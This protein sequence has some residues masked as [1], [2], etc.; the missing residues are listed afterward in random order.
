MAR[1]I[2][3]LSGQGRGHT[4]RAMAISDG[5]RIRRHEVVFCG[6]G[7]ARD[8]LEARGETVLPVPQLVQVVRDNQ[9]LTASTVIANWPSIRDL[10]NIVQ[11]LAG[12]FRAWQPD[13]IITDFEAFSWRAAHVLDV[14]VISLNHQQ[15]VTE[16]RYSL[17]SRHLYHASVARIIINIV[18]PKAPR[19][20]LLTSF[21]FPPVRHPKSTVIVP[22]IIR[23]NVMHLSPSPGD[24]FLVYYNQPEGSRRLLDLLHT[25][26]HRY[27]VYN[28]PAP[29]DPGRYPNLTFKPASVDSFLHDLAHCRGVLCTAGFTLMS[30]ALYLGKP[31]LAVPNRGIFEQTLNAVFLE[32]EQLGRSVID[33]GVTMEDLTDFDAACDDLA[34]GLSGRRSV[35]NREALDAIE[36]VLIS[37]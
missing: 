12:T 36:A 10:G 2:Y 13:L 7:A 33:R 21:Y 23:P 29:Q 34:A 22:P 3:A 19:L 9:V 4:S 26:G 15:V 5:L 11:D 6:S 18:A 37:D 25:H 1:I 28:F 32:R 17:S 24:Y 20:T 35:G 16:T 14:P 27:I 30:E 31:L 8:I